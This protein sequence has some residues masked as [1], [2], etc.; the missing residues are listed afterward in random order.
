M[1]DLIN[2][3]KEETNGEHIKRI[4]DRT[5]GILKS[6]ML[7]FLG[8]SSD[9]ITDLSNRLES[10]LSMSESSS[11]STEEA[12]SE[13]E[14]KC[15]S[16]TG[17]NDAT[18]CHMRKLHALPSLGLTFEDREALAKHKLK[19][20]STLEDSTD[21][22]D[23]MITEKSDDSIS[24]S[25]AVIIQEDD[26]DRSSLKFGDLTDLDRDLSSVHL[27]QSIDSNMDVGLV[28]TGPDP[29][30]KLKVKQEVPSS[31][32]ASDLDGYG[33]S[34]SIES[35]DK[36][37]KKYWVRSGSEG[38]VQSW[39]SSLSL[40]SQSDEISVEFMRNFVV[41]L[42]KD[43]AGIQLDQ[44]AKFGQLCQ[45]ETGRLWFSRFVNAQ[46]GRSKRVNETTFFSLIQYFAIVL[47]ECAEADDFSPAKSLMN[48]CF[49]FYLEEQE[50][51]L[52][53]NVDRMYKETDPWRA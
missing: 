33:P 38:S 41:H 3:S 24:T 40:D 36:D 11:Y 25:V 7:T 45:N 12:I 30:D 35:S 29:Y 37:G 18:P 13:H 52:K 49:T 17:C 48:M 46:R 22:K 1:V 39:A 21:I 28:A 51:M 5:Q 19:H 4:M 10:A 34:T 53:D 6:R 20:Q 44:K 47:F 9:I 31:G 27:S 15:S 14:S 32:S 8:N 2:S 23:C 50:K 26:T 16:K 43:S 42:F